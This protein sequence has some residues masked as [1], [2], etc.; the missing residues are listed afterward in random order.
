MEP[1]K[2]VAPTSRLFSH[3]IL[4]I[5]DEQVIFGE[6]GLRGLKIMVQGFPKKTR[7]SQKL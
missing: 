3:N 6:I 7:V 2:K 4:D 5:K 1:Q